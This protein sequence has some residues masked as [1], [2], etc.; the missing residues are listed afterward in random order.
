LTRSSWLI[1]LIL[2]LFSIAVVTLDSSSGTDLSGEYISCRLIQSGQTSHLYDHDPNSFNSISD[3]VW[4]TMAETTGVPPSTLL[5]TFMK[6]PLWPYILQPLCGRMNFP[7][8]NLIFRIVLCVC[9]AALIW[10]TGYF[11]AP[12]FFKPLWVLLFAAAWLRADPLRQA[13]ELSQTHIIFLLLTFLAVLW[14]RTG[15][16]VAA[17]ISLA[18]AAAAKITPGAMIVYWLM[19][20]QKKAAVSFVVC[21]IV[22]VALTVLAVGH[23]IM[24][25]FIHSMSRAS[26]VLLLSEGNQS[27]AA[28]WM[29][30]FVLKNEALGFQTLPLPSALKV[31]CLGLVVAS[32]L[33]G[34]Y[35]DRRLSGISRSLPPYG[36]VF[37]VLG[38]TVFTPIAWAHYYVILVVP[39]ILLLDEFLRRRSYAALALVG[40]IFLFANYPLFLRHAGYMHLTVPTVVR[41]QFY[42]GILAMAAMLLLYRR[43][44][45]E[46]ARPDSEG[47]AHR[48]VEV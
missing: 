9:M 5:T 20:K 2:A 37:A 42:A 36:A 17:G 31:L 7:S 41:G 25:D 19:T 22:L 32:T 24:T 43:S 40:C 44:L 16:P 45:T 10:I 48:P 38:A 26:N 34:G 18:T 3:P 11:W 27:L 6:T 4:R 29:G 28:W 46:L 21:S 12:R 35:C 47:L 30:D 1:A 14:A 33:V 13:V 15:R 23:T 8:F 39:L